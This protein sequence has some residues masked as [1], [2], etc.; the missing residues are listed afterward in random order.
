MTI[1]FLIGCY[2]GSA[3]NY[4]LF[5][6]DTARHW[7]INEMGYLRAVRMDS[8]RVSGVDTIFYP[9]MSQLLVTP[10][11]AAPTPGWVGNAVHKSPGGIYTINNFYGDTVIINSNANLGDSWQ[12]Y[13]DSS[14]RYYIA[15]ITRT[16]TMT[17][18]GALDSIKVIKVQAY[19]PSL[20][21]NDYVNNFTIIL[22][23][24]NGFMQCFDLYH[25][26][27][28]TIGSIY[29]NCN[30][31]YFQLVGSFPKELQSFRLFNFHMPTRMEIF[32]FHPGEVFEYHRSSNCNCTPGVEFYISDSII[33]RNDPDPYHA[34]I[35]FKRKL[36]GNTYYC[37]DPDP[38]AHYNYSSYT[39]TLRV[40][41]S[42]I[43]T[44]DKLPEQ[45]L[46]RMAYYYNSSDTSECFNSPTIRW[47]K[48]Y[49][50]EECLD[51]QLHK[52]GLGS[53]IK[54]TCIRCP[55][56]EPVFND[57]V[58]LLTFS[59]K[60]ENECG[61]RYPMGI[62]NRLAVTNDIILQPNPANSSFKITRTNNQFKHQYKMRN[63]TGTIVRSGTLNNI[64]EAVD[65]QTLP[66]GLYF[67]ILTTDSGFEVN[68]KIVITH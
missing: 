37:S 5:K 10:W 67:I 62:D 51:P 28:R 8:I 14:S 60:N 30:E 29:P 35:A 38:L 66:D 19:S 9:F 65:T 17:V 6:T 40:D 44:M 54:D 57:D 12:F 23:K 33:Y 39:D 48:S 1:I 20:D 56:G 47:Q 2:I 49:T 34:T 7:Y 31:L 4:Q 25:F 52:C 26:P 43:A 32:D 13:N 55:G 15:T 53:L 58:T 42:A 16:D 63:T 50:F 36:Y 45:Y 22:S 18:L 64:I 68:K 21:T 11:F 27:Y 61:T 59:K 46:Q 24:S 41:T 3:Q